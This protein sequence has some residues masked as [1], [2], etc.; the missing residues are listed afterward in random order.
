MLALLLRRWPLLLFLL[1]LAAGP[2]RATHLLGGEMTYRYLDAN[3]PAAAPVRYE[4]T[5]TI[6]N[7]SNA[8]AA[9]PNTNAVVGIYNPSTGAKIQLVQGTNV[10]AGSGTSVSGGSMDITNYTISAVLQPKV[11]AGCAVSGPAQPFRLQKFVGVVNLPATLDGYY[12]VFTRSARNVDVT[13]L[14]TSGNNQPLTLYTTMAPALRPNRSP[15]FSDTAVAIVCQSDTTI[16]L[17]NAVDADGDRLVYSFGSP[18]GTFASSGANLPTIFPPLPNAI[19]YYN[20]YSTAAPFGTGP[21]NFAML[22]ASTG[23]AKYGA[24]TQGKYVVAV[25]VSEY[26][27]INGREVLVGTTR[28]DLQLIVAQCPTTKAPVLPSAVVTPRSY[29]IEA[30][31]VLSIPITAT[32]ADGHPLVM[33]LNSAL[34]DGPGGFAATFNNSPGSV[35]SGGLTGTASASGTG[36][37]TGTFVYNSAC[38]DARPTPYDIALTVK[39]VGCGGKT[40]A[41]VIRITVTKPTGPT[42]VAGDALVCAVNTISTYTASGGTAPG[43]SWRVV[44]GTFVNGRTSNPVQVRWTTTGTGLVVARGVSS[45]GCLTDSV[46][47]TVSVA[48]AGALAVTGT[49]SVCQGGS[50][51]LTVAGGTGPFVLT[52]GGATQTGPG[53]FTVTPTQTTTY[54]ITSTVTTG[55]CAGVGQATVTVL[56]L[57]AADAVVGPQ[58]VCPTITGVAYAI[59][60]PGSTAYQWAVTGGTIASGQGTAAITVNWGPAGAGAVSAYATNVQGCPSQVFT[61]PVRINPVL[62][63]ARP[64]GPTSVCQADGPYPYQTALTNGSSYAWQ[65]FGSARGTLVNTLNTTSITF[66]QAGLAKL[67]VTETSNPTGGICRGVSDTLY[68]TVKPSP[69]ANLAILGPARFCVNSGAQTYSLPGAAGSTYVFQLNGTTIAN[70]NGTVSIAA[71]T[72]VGTYTLT[73]RETNAG[74]CVGILYTRTFIV[75]PRPGALTISGPRFGCPSTLSLTYTVANPT[76]SSTYQWAVTGG[77]LT[78]GQGTATITVGFAAG[79]TTSA[80][81]S[82]TETSQYGCAGTPVAITI[83]PDNA[84]A[85]QLTLASVVPT[86]NSKVTLTFSVA[87]P[88]TTPNP[89]RVLR[90]DAGSTGAFAQVGTVAATAT[91]YVDA[92]AT[93]AQTAYEYS[94]TL[95]NGC[96]DVFTAP[97]SAT[98]VLLKA[99]AMPGPGGRNQG[100]THLTWTAYQGFTVAG[101]R[102]YQQNDNAGYNL[103]TTLPASARQIDVGNTVVASSTGFNQCFRVVA[104]SNEATLRESNSNTSCVGFANK[105]A[106]YNIITPN[107][108]GQNDLL[109]IDNVTLY[110]GNSL[111]VFNRWGREIYATSN[112]NNT[113]NAWGSNPSLVAGV[114]YYLFKLADGTST[115]GWVEVVK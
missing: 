53:P 106:F 67:V 42:A 112:Y 32:Q 17:N 108:D 61:L 114:Y 6:Y 115:K 105:T 103:Q 113:T 71:S 81:V 14:N 88:G 48:P 93:A 19:T 13:N 26:R 69:A 4:I 2:A 95:T 11:P 111:T 45:Y 7:N 3:G 102:V 23:I 75:D 24:A 51:T 29:T 1:V 72:A 44:G 50:T 100:S 31:Q 66:T 28:R 15:V 87:N 70:T 68:I 34:L 76:P 85:P 107:G 21:G 64:T 96:G 79:T 89:V 83:M 35:A 110:P 92:T 47:Q 101:Y 16:S 9:Q 109:I 58:S 20:G 36:S 40:V 10:L 74:G 94:L 60:K 78:S 86:D 62:Q 99:V 104:F 39:D 46:S 65:L 25:D 82:V 37:V 52:G 57:P 30:G 18:F 91:T 38:A 49:L 80:T 33:T 77:T 73:A 59:E 90:R 27:T 55:G 43:I 22:N 97:V 5:V 63:T 84:Q 56:P 12:A 54:T 8:G 98:T 41:D